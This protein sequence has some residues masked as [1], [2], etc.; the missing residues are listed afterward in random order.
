[1]NLHGNCFDFLGMHP[2]YRKFN[3]LKDYLEYVEEKN[4]GEESLT[5][6]PKRQDDSVWTKMM[7]CK[8]AEE[9]KHVLMTEKPREA[10]LHGGQIM[11][12]WQLFCGIQAEQITKVYPPGY[13]APDHPK[14]EPIREIQRW[15]QEA[16]N[17][18][19]QGQ[20]YK[21]CIVHGPAETGKTTYCRS[22]DPHDYHPLNFSATN[23]DEAA[24]YRICDDCKWEQVKHIA[25][26]LFTGNTCGHVIAS[27]KWV[28]KGKFTA[29]PTLWLCNRYPDWGEDTDW[30]ESQTVKV[31]WTSKVYD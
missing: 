27:E 31:E 17:R 26:G 11:A 12:N 23:H 15:Y 4:E 18:F 13:M 7:Q 30:W 1:M 21:L 6:I 22:M 20:R 10:L 28:P 3:T 16:R 29:L 5:N 25:S 2:N 9:A 14:F 8:T 24:K 19:V